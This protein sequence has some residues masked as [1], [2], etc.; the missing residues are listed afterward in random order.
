M[1]MEN[2]IARGDSIRS[3]HVFEADSS[4]DGCQDSD[5]Y[6]VKQN[7]CNRLFTILIESEPSE[8][9]FPVQILIDYIKQRGY[10]HGPLFSLP[11]GDAVPINQF[12]TELRRVLIFCGLDCSRYKSHSFRIGAVCYAAEKGFS[13]AQISGLGR[14]SSD[15][16][17]IYTRPPSLKAN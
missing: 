17:K 5:K 15:P 1:Q 16:F 11:S 14:W 12:N 4:R 8:R 13:D 3:S 10:N 7:T 6:K 2:T 9:F